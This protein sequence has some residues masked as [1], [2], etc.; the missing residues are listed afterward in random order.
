VY[1]VPNAHQ[2]A[3]QPKAPVV[4]KALSSAGQVKEMIKL[5]PQQVAV[6][7]LIPVSRTAR[8]K[9]SEPVFVS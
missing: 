9:L 6:A 1:T 3:Y 4:V 7:K 5:K 8:G 2:A